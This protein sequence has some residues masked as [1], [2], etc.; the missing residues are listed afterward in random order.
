MSATLD[1]LFAHAGARFADNVA[2][3]RGDR[4][5]TFAEVIDQGWRLAHVLRSAGLV[6]GDKVAA[7]LGIRVESLEVYVGLALGGYTAVHVNDRLTAPELDHVLTDSGARALVTTDGVDAVAAT[8]DEVPG[9]AAWVSVSEKV[10]AGALDYA[11][12]TAAADPTPTP[13]DLDPESTALIAY[14][15]GTTGFPKGV[16]VSHRAVTNCIK[17]VP[18]AYRFPL[19]GHCA[20]PG[21]WSFASG[22]WGVIFPHFY[23]GGTVSFTAGM[24]PQEWGAHMVENRSTFTLGLTPLIPGLLQALAAYPAALGTLQGVLHSGGPLP[25]ELAQDLVAVIGDRLVET[26]GMTEVIGPITITNRTDWSGLGGADDIFASVGRPLPTASV[27]VVDDQ[28][29]DLPPGEVGELLIEADTCFSGYH[30]NPEKTAQAL[31]DGWYHTGDLG[32]ADAAGYLYLTGRSQELIISGGANVYPAEVERVLL[33][34]DDV[35]DVAVFGEPDERWGEAVSAAVVRRA[36]SELGDEELKSFARARLAG[37]KKPGHVYFVDELPR[38]ASMK[39]MKHVL[40]ENLAGTDAV[41]SAE[42]NAS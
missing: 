20:F 38:N 1:R 29:N 16:L 22:L 36:G 14:T 33:Q 4:S 23:T 9:L 26:W 28:G 11:A 7:M 5:R 41:G 18:Y 27:R 19:Q 10:P 15:S 34:H 24:T 17:L 37:Y 21:G 40:K 6:P 12:A 31:R 3:T 8:A 35:V 30:G 13:V 32:Y 39:V 2:V 25:P 42:R